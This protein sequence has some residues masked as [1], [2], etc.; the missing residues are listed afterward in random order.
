MQFVKE[1][2]VAFSLPRPGKGVTPSPT[3]ATGPGRR[4][5]SPGDVFLLV[6]DLDT[7]TSRRS[8]YSCSSIG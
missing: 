1:R 4:C 3:A 7:P 6:L 8:L 5:L 2:E